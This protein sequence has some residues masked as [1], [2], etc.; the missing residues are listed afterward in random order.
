MVREGH[1]KGIR[2]DERV[3][4]L[5]RLTLTKAV[6]LIASIDFEPVNTVQFIPHEFI[7]GDETKIYH[8]GI[9]P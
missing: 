4:G 8:R 6:R 3:V 1:Q 5:L 2:K 7:R 9:C